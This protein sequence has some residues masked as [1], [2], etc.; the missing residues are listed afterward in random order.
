LPS[1]LVPTKF[2]QREETCNSSRNFRANRHDP[3]SF[4]QRNT[5]TMSTITK[6]LHVLPHM[7]LDKIAVNAQPTAL[8]V[9]S[10][11]QQVFSNSI[12]VASTAGGGGHGHLG[13]VMG[14][15]E[16]L[17]VSVGNVA[18][19]APPAAVF[20]VFAADA[21]PGVVA[22]HLEA[23]K[24]AKAVV[25]KAE[26]LEDQQ[27]AQILQAVPAIYLKGLASRRLGFVGV[28]AKS[29]LAYLDLYYGAITCDDLEDNLARAKAPWNPNH[30]IEEVFE[31]ILNA[32]DFAA[33]GL[34][35]IT[36]AAAVRIAIKIFEDS[37]VM[38]DAVKDWRKAPAAERIWTNVQP[39]FHLA[40]KERLRIVTANELGFANATQ[41][42]QPTQGQRP[43][44]E[45]AP[46]ATNAT[47][48]STG[49]NTGIY[50]CWTHG[51]TFNAAHTS[52]TC[53]HK[54]EGHKDTATLRNML[55]GTNKIPRK[56]NER[57]Y[58]PATTQG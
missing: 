53:A 2:R 51:M 1:S 12:S 40:N 54:N 56:R 35:P 16:Y 21:N 17:T 25:Q 24:L 31:Q 47:N 58:V 6:L 10:L 9:R 23:Y 3:F 38:D 30:P 37:G 8:E 15:A 46:P 48:N 57:A 27:K 44:E 43:T 5:K 52:A 19:A 32:L 22:T 7:E 50:Y 13:T 45:A 14:D 11:Q 41:G 42:Q 39:R 20:P 55:G 49:G 33:A 36:P 4:E 34:D 26:N 28:T 29:M 18:W